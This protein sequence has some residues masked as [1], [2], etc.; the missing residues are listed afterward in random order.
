MSKVMNR[1][2][3]V[4]DYFKACGVIMGMYMIF[5]GALYFNNR[6]TQKKLENDFIE[7]TENLPKE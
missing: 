1:A 6:K 7:F 5:L 2:I 4:G 3:T